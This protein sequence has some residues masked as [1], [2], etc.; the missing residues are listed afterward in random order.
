VEK[1]VD[2]EL[3]RFLAKGP[4][5]DEL[6]RVKTQTQAAFIRGLERIGGFGGKSDTLAM[7]Q[8]FLGRADA[9]KEMLERV[10]QATPR[11]VRDAARQ[12]L[13]DGVYV[14]EVQP[15]P[16]FQPSAAVEKA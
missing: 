15:L 8:V 6:E 10:R 1:A 2:E 11:D 14:L 13:S 7:N 3:A 5:A 16:E 4:T 9:W 12:W